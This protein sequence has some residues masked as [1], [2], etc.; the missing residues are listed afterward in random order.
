MKTFFPFLATQVPYASLVVHE[1]W[2][3]EYAKTRGNNSRTDGFMSTHIAL[4]EKQKNPSF[5]FFL[6]LSP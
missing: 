4:I 3:V 6:S 5:F 1:I 2:I